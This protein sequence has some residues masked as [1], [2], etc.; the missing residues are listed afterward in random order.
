MAAASKIQEMLSTRI[1]EETLEKILHKGRLTEADVKE[2]LKLGQEGGGGQNEELLKYG[3]WMAKKLNLMKITSKK[4]KDIKEDNIN[5][6]LRQNQR[7]LEECNLL[8]TENHV[9]DTEI[10]SAE[11]QI[12]EITRKEQAFRGLRAQ[13]TLL[14]Q[15]EKKFKQNQQQLDQQQRRLDDVRVLMGQTGVL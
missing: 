12:E 3:S 10:R 7:L 5:I 2:V 14:N 15:L 11:D 8:R 6:V 4:V 9:Y 1:E 13:Q